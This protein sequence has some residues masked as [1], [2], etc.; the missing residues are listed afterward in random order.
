MPF[1]DNEQGRLASSDP[2]SA[3]LPTVFLD[4]GVGH[5]V[6]GGAGHPRSGRC[7]AVGATAAFVGRG[8]RLAA[9]RMPLGGARACFR[10]GEFS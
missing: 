9:G 10:S 2:L 1:G 6:P 7:L 5:Y 4:V 3:P 8:S